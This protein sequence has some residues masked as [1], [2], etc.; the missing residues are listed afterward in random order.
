M[1]KITSV[2]AFLCSCL[3]HACSQPDQ[4]TPC[5]LS[6]KVVSLSAPLFL[7]GKLTKFACYRSWP[8]PSAT[9]MHTPWT[10]MILKVL[11]T[12]IAARKVESKMSQHSDEYKPSYQQC[13]V[14]CQELTIVCCI[15]CIACHELKECL[16]AGLFPAILGHEAAGVVESVGEGVESVQPGDHVIPCYQ[17]RLHDVTTANQMQIKS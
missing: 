12:A 10:V 1:Q 17:A 6:S 16:S 13:K 2:L 3:G 14:Q 15:S 11:H 9:Q 8:L 7:C 5:R 4:A